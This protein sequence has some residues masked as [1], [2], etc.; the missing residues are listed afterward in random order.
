MDYLKQ[1]KIKIYNYYSNYNIIF[2]YK[3]Y[4]INYNITY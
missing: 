3:N 4:I 1:I 2:N